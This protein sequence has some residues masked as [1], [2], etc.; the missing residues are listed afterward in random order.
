MGNKI[1]KTKSWLITPKIKPFQ[2][3]IAVGAIMIFAFM[4]TDLF[5]DATDIAKITTY[6]SLI[7]VTALSGISLV[8]LKEIAERFKEIIKNDKLDAWAKVRAF[9][10]LGVQVLAKAGEA[11]DLVN[12]EQFTNNGFIADKKKELEKELE[13]LTKSSDE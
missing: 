13:E 10:N 4:E 9:M 1:D 11:W 5:S 8:D 6:I 3:L 12:E 7:V 2:F